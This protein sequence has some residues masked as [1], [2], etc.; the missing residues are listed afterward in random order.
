MKDAYVNLHIFYKKYFV[1]CWLS[2]KKIKVHVCKKKRAQNAFI[3]GS[4]LGKMLYVNYCANKRTFK[5]SFF[6]TVE[7][8]Y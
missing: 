6:T 3:L 5:T 1:I 2:S 4:L 8:F 7:D